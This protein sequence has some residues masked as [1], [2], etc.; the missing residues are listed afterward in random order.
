MLFL[1]IKSPCLPINPDRDVDPSGQERQEWKCPVTALGQSDIFPRVSGIL[2]GK[3][4]LH[5]I[6]IERKKNWEVAQ[7]THH[8]ESRFNPVSVQGMRTVV[9][10]LDEAACPRGAADGAINPGINQGTRA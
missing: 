4:L 10:Q 2:A 7:C 6:D 9:T 8:T 3:Q 5:G 1:I